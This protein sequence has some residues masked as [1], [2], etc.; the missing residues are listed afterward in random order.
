MF[1][2][3]QKKNKKNMDDR[4][5]EERGEARQKMEKCKYVGRRFAGQKTFTERKTELK[6]KKKATG[7]ES[8]R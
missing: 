5:R 6:L 1:A 7:K 2:V 4:C 3:R 8:G